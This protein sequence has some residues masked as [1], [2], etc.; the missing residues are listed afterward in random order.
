M[1]TRP[2]VKATTGAYNSAGIIN[3]IF[4]S[5]LIDGFEGRHVENT[6]ESI[7]AIGQELTAYKPRMNQFRDA[8]VNLIGMMR[9]HYM[10]FN[11]PW[12]WAKQGKLEFGETIE[13][14]WLGLAEVFPY[15]P[16]KSETRILKQAKPDIMTAFHHINY[17]EVYKVTINETSLKNAFLSVDGLVNFIE[18]VIGSLSRSV[19]VDEFAAVKYLLA[20]LLLDGK[21][22]TQVIPAITKETA[23]D[24]ATAIATTTNLFQFPSTEYTMAGNENTTPI[25]RLMILE[26]ADANALIKVNSL[27]NAFNVEYVKFMGNVEMFDSLATYNWERMDKIFAEDPG[28]K[29]F[30]TE[31]LFLL[32]QVKLIAM[33]RLFMQIYDAVDEMEQPFIN[34][35][36]K[37][38]NYF[39]H[40]WQILSASPFHNCVAYTTAQS[41]V[42]AVSV[43]P[44]TLTVAK[45]A[46][47]AIT[48]TITTTGF[49]D[50][51]VI[52][53]LTGSTSAEGGVPGS[54]VD[55]AGV[56][57]VGMGET[58]TSLT[59]TATSKAD[60]TKSASATVTVG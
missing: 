34:G 19:E 4:H 46:N 40:K 9:L 47:A 45:G 22:K 14:I 3:H 51:S 44:K 50:A 55:G 8:L 32:E 6:T 27:A 39:Y 20:T 41:T 58:A 11:F 15:N 35:E 38:T 25:D 28:Y 30:T 12:S 16:E 43:T 26:S 54:F 59:V 31:Q 37:F 33:D 7:K 48:A 23:D 56:L 60:P 21:I 57:H 13:Q 24:V 52:W 18:G 1:P 2:T 17:K 36:G 10:V 53:S 29:R 5:G 42:T 49:A